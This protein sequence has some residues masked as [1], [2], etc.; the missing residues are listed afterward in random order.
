MPPGEVQQLPPRLHVED[1]NVRVVAAADQAPADRVDVQTADE[2]G[3]GRHL[4]HT[5]ARVGIPDP[6]GAVV[7]GRGDVPAVLAELRAGQALRV[8]RELPD[9]RAR[10]DVPQLDLEVARAAHD[11]VTAHL[12]RVDGSRVPTQLSEQLT[13]LAVP[14]ADGNVLGARHNVPVIKHQ[15]QDRRRVVL[16]QANGS[17]ARRN[18]VHD[19]RRVGTARYQDSVVILQAK[20]RGVVVVREGQRRREGRVRPWAG[21]CGS[22]MSWLSIGVTQDVL[23]ADDVRRTNDISAR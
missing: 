22:E 18:R 8:A 15:V 13:R 21:L 6:D 17:V 10:A 11:G 7:A 5:L 14:H 16:Q 9:A 20:N 23:F 1:H 2:V 3:M 19:A 4:A 12:H